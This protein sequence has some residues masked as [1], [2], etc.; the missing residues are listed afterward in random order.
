MI[1]HPIRELDVWTYSS[2]EHGWIAQFE[3]GR[4][5]PIQF[6]GWSEAEVMHKAEAFRED[7]IAKHEAKYVARKIATEKAKAKRLAK[8]HAKECI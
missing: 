4:Q 1:Q 3:N 7:T 6:R 8:Q 5:F 2:P